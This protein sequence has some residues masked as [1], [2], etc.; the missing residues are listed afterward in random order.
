VTTKIINEMQSISRTWQEQGGGEYI[1]CSIGV[2]AYNEEANIGRTLRAILEQQGPSICIE[3]VIV[4][5][6]GC[7]DRTVPIVAEIALQEPRVRL[8][9][10]EKREGKASAI[11]LFLKQAISP[12]VVL[13]GADVIPET[14]A[15]EYLCAPFKDPKIGMVGG[16]PIP[17]ND[18]ATF[19]GHAV[20]LLWR[21]HDHLARMHPKL[22]EVIAFRNVI[23][24]I[25]TNSA[26]DEISIQALI[27]QLGYQLLYE[28][29]CIVYNKGPLNIR[30]FLKQRRRI[31]AGHLK[32]REQQNYEA[33]TMKVGPIA[34]QLI[35]CR[36]FTMSNPRQTVWTCGTIL[37]E[38]YARL[39]GYY[40]YRR[41]REHH[42][43]QMVDS[44][45]EL[46]A[47]KYK[48]RRICNAQSVIV[49]RF[50][51]DGGQ[52]NTINPERD[53]R[54]ATEAARK[55]LPLLRTKIR[56][57]DKLSINGPG[58]MTAVIRAE[59]HAAEMV[60]KRIQE[61][62]EATSVRIGM[63]GRAVKVTVAYSS[64]T[65]ALKVQNGSMIVSS[66][67]GSEAMIAALEANGVGKSMV[68]KQ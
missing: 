46:E 50:I 28:P 60:A 56:K 10:Q 19:M 66:P 2:M 63:R 8:C 40:D 1:G 65:F 27:S 58:I 61:V 57:E 68:G 22:G 17:V 9:I 54:E 26:V 25:P 15:L 36:D 37:L 41:K 32:V 49:F 12:V 62:V 44:T 48:V 6:S 64:L 34:H 59:Q 16:R 53:D 14:S 45:K 5:A 7:T 13:L 43:W 51:L 31:Y 42:I 47:G 52:G 67:L 4:V 33:S 20:H 18:P 24:G 11:N 30:D 55:L 39:Q 23:S 38:G 21:L 35:A 3:E 29:A